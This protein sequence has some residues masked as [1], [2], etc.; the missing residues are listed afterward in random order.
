MQS[1]GP[2]FG[3]FGAGSLGLAWLMHAE[4]LP[5]NGLVGMRTGATMASD[6][7]WT[8]GHHDSAW[9]VALAG[10]VLLGTAGWLSLDRRST[11]TR[12]TAV[13]GTSIGLAVALVV[14]GAIQADRAARGTLSTTNGEGQRSAV[15]TPG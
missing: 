7:A 5:R 8:A 10:V 15:T 2:L 6:A 11:A 13:L 4:R 12:R 9:A 1:T 3:V 14:L